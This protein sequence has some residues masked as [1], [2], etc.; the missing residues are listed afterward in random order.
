[1]ATGSPRNLIVGRNLEY[2]MST[3]FYKL[4]LKVYDW[5]LSFWNDKTK[6]IQNTLITLNLKYSFDQLS[7][8]FVYWSDVPVIS[9][10]LASKIY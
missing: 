9:E 5:A 3:T 4:S 1:M 2:V 8:A 10:V 7:S 6:T